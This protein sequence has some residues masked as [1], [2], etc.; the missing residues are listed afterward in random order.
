MQASK[1]SCP[2]PTFPV[3]IRAV[4]A[5]L[6]S[7][8][9]VSC[10]QPPARPTLRVVDPEGFLAEAAAAGLLPALPAEL[11]SG[12]DRPA[13]PVL[14]LA[15]LVVERSWGPE[16]PSGLVVEARAYVL[17]RRL[18]EP[19]KEVSAAEALELK[20]SALPL[21]ELVLPL[22]GIPVDGLYPGEPGYALVRWT[23]L[24]LRD[25]S[26]ERPARAGSAA[27]LFREKTN[28]WLAGL[29]EARPPR[30]KVHWLGAV[31]DVM[32][33]R[34]V[35]DVLAAEG[36]LERVFGDA[37]PLLRKADYLFGN[38][39]GAVTERGKPIGKR[40]SFRFPPS[41]LG[42]LA[43]AGFDYLSIVNNHSYDFGETGFLDTLSHLSASPFGSSGAGRNSEEAKR[44]WSARLGGY[45]DTDGLELRVLSLG[46]YPKD[47]SGFDGKRD[48]EAKS[49]RAGVLWDGPEAIAAVRAMSS[50]DSFDVVLVHGG[51]E[52]RTAPRRGHRLRYLEYVDAGADLV[53]GSHS[54]VVQGLEA[55]KGALVAHSLGNF[56]FPGMDETA[57]GEEGLLLLVGVQDGAARYVRPVPVRLDGKKVEVDKGSALLKRFFSATKELRGDGAGSAPPSS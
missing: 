53:L 15:E 36:G 13:E 8:A 44:P 16:A 22:A 33:G 20:E 6:L 31:G 37:L 47:S 50:A 24:R 25:L 55:H 4:S 19:E 14:D 54:H 41:V 7:L 30:A 29:R 57:Y 39:E 48:T 46:S 27:L 42:S 52:W 51:E 32:P 1:S 2:V 17:A 11:L 3:S 28:A 56:L 10:G 40:Y 38:L 12:G 9:V 35:S 5:A 26:P 49:D 34:G 23:V 18:W 21:E 43:A 45:A